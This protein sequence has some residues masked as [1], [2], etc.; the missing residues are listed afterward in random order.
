[1]RLL[2]LVVLSVLFII[3]MAGLSVPLWWKYAQP[4]IFGLPN[5]IEGVIKNIKEYLAIFWNIL[6]KH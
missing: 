5:Y 6:K 3:A 2:E 4:F 1:M